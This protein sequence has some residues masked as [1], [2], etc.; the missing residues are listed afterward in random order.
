[1]VQKENMVTFVYQ[2]V[3][4][5]TIVIPITQCGGVFVLRMEEYPFRTLLPYVFVLLPQAS[6]MIAGLREQYDYRYTY[7]TLRINP[8]YNAHNSDCMN[9]FHT[10]T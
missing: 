3:S 5:N 6:N 7:A 9:R 2:H 10:V 8:N 1:M 4:I